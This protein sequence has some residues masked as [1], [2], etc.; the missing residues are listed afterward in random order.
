MTQQ[1]PYIGSK[2]SLI[3]KL[4]IRYEGIL[5]TVDSKES[6]IALSKVQ[7]FGTEDRNA[8]ISVPPQDDVYDYIIFKANDIKDLIVCETPKPP[9][10]GL[11]FDPAI[12]E[13]G[14]IVSHGEKPAPPV[15]SERSGS[16]NA[17]RTSTPRNNTTSPSQQQP[18]QKS[19]KNNDNKS[20]NSTHRQG[21]YQNRNNQN[22]QNGYEGHSKQQPRNYGSQNRN[23]D[24]YRQGNNQ[25]R[26]YEPQNRNTYNNSNNRGGPRNQNQGNGNRP[27][28][29]NL[30]FENDYD[31]EKA[32]VQFKETLDAIVGDVQNIKI[33]DSHDNDA[34]SVKSGDGKDESF[35]DKEKSFFDSISCEALEKEEGMNTRPDW[36]KERLTNQETFG[37]QSVRFFG[38]RRGGFNNR[39][40]GYN[41]RG[42]GYGNR[43]Q[44]GYD[45]N[46]RGGGFNN[47]RGGGYNNRG[48]GYG[49]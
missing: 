9:A 2:I 41:N 13:K 23:G 35:Y 3:S 32:Y 17:T 38:Y 29:N 22:R 27:P 16:A 4:D 6:T 31:F 15:G 26:N 34:S 43:Q 40:G 7:S 48:N 12:K 18:Q 1:T 19:W 37:H 20:N 44:G 11:P 8:A 49:N 47:R 14:S 21:G 42:N 5:Y 33:D 30:K 46:R 36:R 28:R 45:N 25:S 24:N 10:S 39:G